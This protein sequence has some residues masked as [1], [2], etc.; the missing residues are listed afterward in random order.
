[1]DQNSILKYLNGMEKLGIDSNY[2]NPIP[3][4]EDFISHSQWP[5]PGPSNPI[6]IPFSQSK[7]RSIPVPILSL[8]DPLNGSTN[9][10][11]SS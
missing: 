4:F 11:L 8:Q 3:I 6:Q 10:K 1:M 9:F 5:N 7:N 2:L